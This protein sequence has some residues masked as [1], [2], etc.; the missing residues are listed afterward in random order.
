MARRA[1]YQTSV[2]A[3]IKGLLADPGRWDVTLRMPGRS[4]AGPL[5]PLTSE[6]AALAERLRA[7]VEHLALSIGD[8]NAFRPEA[9][10][11]AEEFLG[12]HLSR[13][14]HV[15]RQPFAASGHQCAN[16]WVDLPG[17]SHA[18]EIVLVGAHYD[19]VINCPAANDNASGV[20][21]VLEIGRRLAPLYADPSTRPA[22][23]LRLACFAN[24][25]PPHFWT[26]QMGSLVMA[27]ACKAKGENI[28]AMLTPETIGCYSDAPGSQRYPLPLQRWYP[29]RGDFIA[30]LGLSGSGPLVR[31]CVGLFRD[32]AAFPSIGAALPCAVPGIGASDHWSFAQM[33]YPALMITDTAPFRYAHYHTPQDTPD[34]IDFDK[35]A[36]VVEGIAAVVADLVAEPR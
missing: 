28:V 13:L 11:R 23:T 31:R 5:P 4:H 22:R 35:C 30:F 9:Y 3:L 15:T 33:G 19:S 1:Q 8:R 34:K 20:A 32:H 2:R 12:L 7:T 27:R 21:A 10:G 18:Q 29:D 36:R 6:Q 16:L 26:E 25:E 14:G 17:S 24:E